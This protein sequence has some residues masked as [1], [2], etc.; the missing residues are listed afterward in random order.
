MTDMSFH[1]CVW[2][3][4]SENRRQKIEVFLYY[5][6]QECSQSVTFERH[7][8]CDRKSVFHTPGSQNDEL[9]IFNWI[10]GP[11]SSNIVVL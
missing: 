11:I 2:K 5:F 6:E 10:Y 4:E 1:A 3:G 7:M 9:R 8:I